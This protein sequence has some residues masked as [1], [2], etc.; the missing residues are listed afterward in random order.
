M[1]NKNASSV[2]RF[3]VH[4][5]RKILVDNL[6]YMRMYNA[7]SESLFYFTDSCRS[8]YFLCTEEKTCVQNSWRYVAYAIIT[9]VKFGKTMYGAYK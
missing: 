5:Y 4:R 3:F 8:G 1:S 9:I 2:G 6:D 7:A